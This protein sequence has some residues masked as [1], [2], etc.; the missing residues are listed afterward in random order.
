M[1]LPS[2]GRTTINKKL[3]CSWY[4]ITCPDDVML[5]A[6][7]RVDWTWRQNGR[8]FRR[9]HTVICVHTHT[10]THLI[11]ISVSV[12]ANVWRSTSR[13]IGVKNLFTFLFVLIFMFLNVFLK[14]IVTLLLQNVETLPKG[15]M[16]PSGE[17][18]KFEAPRPQH[19]INLL[20]LSI[21]VTNSCYHTICSICPIRDL[22]HS[23]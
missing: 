13:S 23:V 21:N 10:H 20:H 7:S 9:T 11:S 18:G 4:R 15:Q 2:G 12:S 3:H 16:F 6:G 5:V 17:R 22:Q 8:T 1:L 19:P 14:K